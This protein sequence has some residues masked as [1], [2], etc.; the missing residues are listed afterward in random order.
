MD[1]PVWQALYEELS[2]TNFLP[3]TVALESRGAAGARQWI[4]AASPSHPSLIDQGHLVAD[5]YGFVNVPM[6]A[7]IDEDGMIV[8]PPETA[9]S[10]DSFRSMDR[11]NRT[12]PEG[13]R[14]LQRRTR[15]A[16]LDALRDWARNGAQSR[17]VLS[18]D[19]VKRRMHPRDEGRARAAV[20]A[21]LAEYVWRSGYAGDARALLTE[22]EGLWPE[23]WALKRQAWNLED[24]MK[25][26]GDEFWEAVAALGE[27]PYYQPVEDIS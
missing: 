10:T 11:V 21:R 20:L 22:A 23:S 8:R 9:G 14:A 4:E 17:F 7:W 1:L 18:N 26:F 16:Y 13:Q 12:M 25:S 19:E 5:L 3:I 6:A 15:A 2:D 27:E 24:P